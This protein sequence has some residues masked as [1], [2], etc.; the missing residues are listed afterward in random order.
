MGSR[1]DRW[2]LVAKCCYSPQGRLAL[3]N[4]ATSV[5]WP[6]YCDVISNDRGYAGD[7]VVSMMLWPCLFSFKPT[8]HCSDQFRC[9]KPKCVIPLNQIRLVCATIE[10]YKCVRLRIYLLYVVNMEWSRNSLV[11]RARFRSL[12][13]E[14]LCLYITSSRPALEDTQMASGGKAAE[15]WSW[16]LTAI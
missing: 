1:L 11:W 2:A 12:A 3:R 9:S 5:H 14:N 6:I 7:V 4:R 10:V 13:W 8:H 15:E 16:Q